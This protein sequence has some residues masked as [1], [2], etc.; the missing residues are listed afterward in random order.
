[1][2]RNLLKGEALTHMDSQMVWDTCSVWLAHFAER[3]GG[4]LVTF[5]F[6]NLI[7]NIGSANFPQISLLYLSVLSCHGIFRH[8]LLL[9]KEKVRETCTDVK[10]SAHGSA[11]IE[12]RSWSIKIYEMS[13]VRLTV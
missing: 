10:E 5:T 11:S 9:G 1:M 12:S 6:A 2:R 4:R 13:E 8:R 3:I 7:S